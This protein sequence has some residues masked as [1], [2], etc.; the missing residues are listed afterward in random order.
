MLHRLPNDILQHV[1][2]SLPRKWRRLHDPLPPHHL[3]LWLQPREPL[4]PH[5][6]HGHCW[7]ASRGTTDILGAMQRRW[8]KLNK[9]VAVTRVFVC[10]LHHSDFSYGTQFV[11]QWDEPRCRTSIKVPAAAV[12]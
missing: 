2:L 8:G 5:F 7:C 12:S 10:V 6:G 9:H 3:K 11:L 4:D 1:L